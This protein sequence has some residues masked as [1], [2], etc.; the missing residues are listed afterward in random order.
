MRLLLDTHAFLFAISEPER[1][2][3]K[4]RRQLASLEVERWVSVV[5]LWEIAI[6]VQIG[7]LAMPLDESFYTR[8]LRA[9]KARV[10]AMNPQHSLALMRL[11]MHHRDP[12][13]RL[14]IAQ[15]QEEGLTLVRRD[16]AFRAYGV[17]TVW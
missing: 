5:S 15:A 1:L 3:A 11:P 6:K 7:K 9:L 14:L 2:T 8:H 17:A 10:L 4:T 13:D 12:F 16:A